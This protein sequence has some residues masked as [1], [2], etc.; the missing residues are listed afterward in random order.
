[1]VML[2]LVLTSFLCSLFPLI[3]RARAWMIQSGRYDY[4][5]MYV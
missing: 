1:M 5:V 4:I 3:L 2:Q